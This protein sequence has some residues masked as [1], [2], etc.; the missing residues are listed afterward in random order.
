MTDIDLDRAHVVDTPVS[1]RFPIYTRANVAEIWPGPAT[2]LAFTSQTGM[3]FDV[4]WRKALVRFGAFDEDEFDPDNPELM[5]MFYGYP[6][7]NLSAQRVFSVRMPGA[8]PDLIDDAFFGTRSDVPPYE[9]HP[10]DDSPEHTA[11]IVRTIQTILSTTTLPVLDEHRREVEDLRTRRP[12]FTTMSDA[13][14]FEY[15]RPIITTWFAKINVEHMFVTSAASIPIGMV[16]AAASEAGRPELAL[17]VLGGLEEID[18]AVP[19]RVMWELSRVARRSP[20]LTSLFE[21]GPHEVLSALA[22]AQGGDPKAFRDG[23]EKLLTEHGARGR[24]EADLTVPSWEMNP[25][26]PLVTI[27]RMRL[28][29]DDESPTAG[30]GRLA[31]GRHQAETELLAS[32][33]SDEARAEL[34]RAMAAAR[35]FTRARERT[36]ATSVMLLNEARPPLFEI[37]R[38]MTARGIFAKPEDFTLLT[39]DEYPEFLEDPAPWKSTLDERREWHEE[40]SLLEP[41]FITVGMPPVPSTWRRRTVEELLP[42]QP[43]DQL[44]GIG[45]CPGTVTG[46]ARVILDPEEAGDLQPG[47]IMIA[48]ITDPGWTPIFMAASGVVVDIGAPLSHAAIVSRELGI[49]CV[50]SATHASRRIPD[51]SRITLDGSTGLVTVLAHPEEKERT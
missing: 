40:L 13:E 8:S 26:V 19:T 20:E 42:L 2:P 41:P 33:D 22:D 34:L 12:D 21:A 17:A 39:L 50:V 48:P 35:T 32:L 11:R 1:S 5:G 27:D 9:P 43:G 51:G 6:Y 3:D 31:D 49:P 44:M 30:R 15:C 4:A 18:S 23:F 25:A 28:R 37:G 46:V 45:A 24:D 29:R 38:R 10:Q 7:L 14:L 36:K 16:Q 47:E